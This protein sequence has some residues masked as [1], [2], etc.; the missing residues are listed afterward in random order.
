MRYIKT[1]IILIPYFIKY[2]P[3]L[4]KLIRRIKAVD[5]D[6]YQFSDLK[7]LEYAVREF[8]GKKE[9]PE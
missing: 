1:V 6:G 9:N 4:P 2:G 7:E 3:R 8:L 5:D